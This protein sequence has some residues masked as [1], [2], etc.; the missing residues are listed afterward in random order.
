[1]YLLKRR[2]LIISS[3]HLQDTSFKRQVSEICAAKR[4]YEKAARTLEKI[5][6]EN[7]NRPVQES[8]K[9]DIYVSI[10]E[11]W[12]EDED[13]VNAEKFINKAAHIIHLV[14]E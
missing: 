14:K 8:E 4:D 1:M 9:A 12:F 5:N 6:L 10:A 2:Y 3:N 13:A 11:H 7:A